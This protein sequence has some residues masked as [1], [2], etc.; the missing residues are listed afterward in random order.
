MI[1]TSLTGSVANL[2]SIKSTLLLFPPPLSTTLNVDGALTTKLATSSS[3]ESPG[4]KVSEAKPLYLKS[5]VLVVTTETTKV[6]VSSSI[7]SFTDC[8]VTVCVVNHS[9]GLLLKLKPDPNNWI[10]SVSPGE[11]VV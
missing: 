10:S 8:T 2:S 1:T 9:T 5:E 7:S 6:C 4:K 11:R 3:I